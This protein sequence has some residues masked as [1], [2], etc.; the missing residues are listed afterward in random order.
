MALTQQELA[1]QML[2]QLRLL[3]PSVSAEVGT[4][5]RKILD[6]VAQA[7][8]DAQVDLVQLSGALDID[9]K[10]GSKLD[11]FLALFGFGRQKAVAASGF[12]SFGRTSP[13]TQD[14][15]IPAGTQVIAPNQ[16]SSLVSADTLQNVVFET[17]FD[18]TLL[19]GQTSVAAPVRA[20][21]TGSIGNVAANKITLFAANPVYGIHT[22]NNEAA[23]SGG[24]DQEDDDQLK[25]RFKN[26]V[27]RNLAG[28]QDQYIAI[29]ASAATTTKVNVVGPISRY[30]EYI[31]V[32]P[33]DDNSAYDVD[34]DG[35]PDLGLGTVGEYTTAMSTV[36][37][38]KHIYSN[39]PNFISNGQ[40]GSSSVFWREGFDWR[41][42]VL[43]SAKDRGDTR[44]FAATNIDVSAANAPFRPNITF[45]NVYTGT[46]DD[47]VAIRPGDTLLF[48]HSYMSQASRNNFDI[49]VTNCVDV[50]VDGANEVVGSTIFPSPGASTTAAI[51]NTA[52]S[53]YYQQNYRLAGQPTTLPTLGYLLFPLYWQPVVDLPEQIIIST[54]T[55]TSIFYLGEHYFLAE[56]VTE[57][58]GTIRARNGI[59]WNPNA[60]GATSPSD[61]ARTGLSLNEFPAG[62][63]V[64]VDNYVYDRNIVDLQGNLE[65]SKQVTTDVLVH[66]AKLRYFKLDITV[67]YGSGA[68][69]AATNNAIRIAV[70]NYFQS[71]YFGNV[72]QL[73]DL[74]QA[75]HSV[76]GVD[77]VRWSSDLPNSV[78][79]TRVAE[80]SQM[81]VELGTNFSSDFFVKDDELPRL[82]EALS[83]GDESGVANRQ[84]AAVPGIL[85]RAR[86]QNSWQRS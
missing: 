1:A 21:L 24:V 13:S 80:T 55:D 22:V 69:T 70:N 2:A 12:V 42:N 6:T 47:V 4:P 74:L 26:T 79:T 66:R 38:S 58:R 64:A 44:R 68:N 83:S 19:A 62:T 63:S 15:R 37:Y 8:S 53:K 59:L 78:A 52:T 49:N 41:M 11:N 31:Q 67:M 25:V 56:D 43:S 7:L 54:T 14:I 23:I 27:F 35:S 71:Q 82:S 28:T 75:I 39:V 72:I 81:G 30:R 36:P 86:A 48:E 18:T 20:M 33:V 3:D 9:S 40:N 51:V 46:N 32:P 60:N 57:L 85:I 29:A 65:A 50:Y 10:V 16:S 61:V 34:S 76:S 73:S 77:N 45:T 84:W 17:T 5:E